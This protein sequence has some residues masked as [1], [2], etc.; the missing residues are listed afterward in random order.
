MEAKRTYPSKQLLFRLFQIMKHLLPALGLAIIFAVSGFT[1]SVAIPVLLLN[2]GFLAV[3]GQAPSLG[4]LFLL[5]ALAIGR[6]LFRYGEHYFGHYVAFHSLADLRKLVFAKLRRLA[7]AKLDRQDSGSLLKM[8]GEDIEAIEVFFAH[9]VAPVC[10]GLISAFIM[11]VFLSRISPALGFLALLTYLLLAVVLPQNFARHLQK[12][13]S[14][15]A[16]DRTRYISYFLESL[17]AIHDLSQLGQTSKRFSCLEQKSQGLNSIERQV[18]QK[19]FFEQALTFLVVGLSVMGFAILSLF[20]LNQGDIDLTQAG[21]AL[22]AFS[23]SFAPFLE[24]GRLPLGFKRAMNASRQVFSLLDEPEA[25]SSGLKTDVRIESVDINHLNFDYEGREQGLFQGLSARFEKGRI[26][27]IVGGS[28]TGKSTLMKIIMRWYDPKAGQVLLSGQ[29]HQT[30]H[31]QHLQASFAY[32]PQVAQ[33][34]HKSLRENLV[35]GRTDISDEVIWTLAAKCRLKERLERLPEGLDTVIDGE[36]TF[37]AGEAQRLEL[38]RALLKEADCYIFDEPTSN[39]DS[40]NEAAFL[41]IVKEECRG[42]VFLISHRLSTVAFAD[43]VY[44]LNHSQ[45][46]RIKG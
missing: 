14:K 42:M 41:S 17:K 18:A 33:L 40:L 4:F 36:T 19:Q 24:L 20:Q 30:F 22:V 38:M 45:V 2:Q 32:V 31:R 27:G 3:G 39:L 5:L 46:R 11:W 6:G 16:D 26:I 29:D 23:S 7:P 1:V 10:T 44:E 35:L 25:D 37:S 8:I 34:F 9:T 28:G 13:L 12:L 43:E 15:Q 21:L